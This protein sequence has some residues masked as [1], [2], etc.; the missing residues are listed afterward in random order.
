MKIDAIKTTVIGVHSVTKVKKQSDNAQ[1]SKADKLDISREA[2]EMVKN[3]K[4]A[5]EQRLEEIRKRI[6][7]GYYNREDVLREI[8]ERMIQSTDLKEFVSKRNT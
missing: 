3:Q 2:K 5:K 8:A 1:N 7:E 6:A 4:A